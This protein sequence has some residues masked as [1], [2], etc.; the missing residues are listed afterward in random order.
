M[1]IAISGAISTGKTTL[2]KALAEEM[3]VPFIEENMQPIPVQS[4]KT[5]A[6][7]IV[8]NLVFKKKLED[9]AGDFVVDRSPLD[10]VN[11]WQAYR[12]PRKVD[13]FDIVELGERFTADY[14]F[15]VITPWGSI[16]LVGRQEG[17]GG[18]KRVLDEWRQFNGAVRITGLA[19]HF[20]EPAQIIQIPKS[21][22]D[23]DAR[24]AIHNI[25]GHK[26]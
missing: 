12:L 23:H 9:E 17:E 6:A 8:S 4:P 10:M 16:P 1:K 3:R 2:G 11:F 26:K 14:D 21:L 20:F 7:G 13:N 24:L 5:I 18:A 25:I 22:A 19:F 15:V